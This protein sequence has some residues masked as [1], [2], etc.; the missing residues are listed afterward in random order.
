MQTVSGGCME[1][2]KRVLGKCQ[3]NLRSGH[4]RTGQV[5]TMG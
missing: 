3:K 1:G 5:K 4:K 2:M